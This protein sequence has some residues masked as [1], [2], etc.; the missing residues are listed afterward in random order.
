M[1][2]YVVLA[3]LATLLVSIEGSAI[4]SKVPDGFDP[5]GYFGGVRDAPYFPNFNPLGKN[6]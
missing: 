1:N 2:A 3:S 4:L 5:K 6:H